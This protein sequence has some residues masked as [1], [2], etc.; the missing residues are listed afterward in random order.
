MKR[1][2]CL[3]FILTNPLCCFTENP[4][5]VL[6][7]LYSAQKEGGHRI[8]F[9]PIGVYVADFKL[10]FLPYLEINESKH[11]REHGRLHSRDG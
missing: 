7:F 6:F 11:K 10:S 8:F 1:K 3:S 4:F 2:V 9:W 5:S